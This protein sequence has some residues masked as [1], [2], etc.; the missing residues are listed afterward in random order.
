MCK[1]Y[2][3]RISCHH[4]YYHFTFS[5]PV[6]LLSHDFHWLYL[7]KW[8]VSRLIGWE[9]SLWHHH[10]RISPS[11]QAIPPWSPSTQGH[12]AQ[13]IEHRPY[14][15]RVAGSIP[16]M[17]KHQFLF[18]FFD[19]WSEF[20]FWLIALPVLGF[21]STSA[22]WCSNYYPSE[23]VFRKAVGCSFSSND[24]ITSRRWIDLSVPEQLRGI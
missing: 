23:T 1:Y 13:L 19:V 8:P 4:Y 9:V 5:L 2:Q 20:R 10:H 3:S 17:T 16:A 12:I 11:T 15:A 18:V 24:L 7:L 21:S 22:T 6:C 14:T